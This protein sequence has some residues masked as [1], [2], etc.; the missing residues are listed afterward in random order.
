MKSRKN[1]R[2]VQSI[3][4]ISILVAQDPRLLSFLDAMVQDLFKPVVYKKQ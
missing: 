3:I 2:S 1:V 4:W